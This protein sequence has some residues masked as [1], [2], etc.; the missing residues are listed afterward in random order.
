MIRDINTRFSSR[1]KDKVIVEYDEK[2]TNNLEELF[3]EICSWVNWTTF[4]FQF[5]YKLMYRCTW[6][7]VIKL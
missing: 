7:N 5:P 1:S 6:R 2:V 3:S 4:Y